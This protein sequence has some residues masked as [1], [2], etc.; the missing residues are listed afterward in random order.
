MKINV[1]ASIGKH[2]PKTKR[3]KFTLRLSVNQKEEE[4][5]TCLQSALQA[6]SAWTDLMG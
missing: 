4:V 6:K 5:G 3:K 2:G 1:M